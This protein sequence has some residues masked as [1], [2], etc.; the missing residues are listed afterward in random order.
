MHEKQTRK[1]SGND[2]NNESCVDNQKESLRV[3][4]G[5]A[6]KGTHRINHSLVILPNQSCIHNEVANTESIVHI[7]KKFAAF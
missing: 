7:G 6:V 1:T 5:N 3:S 2:N 4:P